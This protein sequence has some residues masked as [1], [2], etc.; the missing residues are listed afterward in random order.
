MLEVVAAF[1]AASGRTVPLDI[2][3]RR[4]GDVAE[5]TADPRKANAGLE[6]SAR[7]GIERM[8]ADV[9]EWQMT[10]PLGFEKKDSS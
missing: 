10:N 3:E 2:V 1:A 5:L 6:W 9:W 7:Y 4:A 8:C